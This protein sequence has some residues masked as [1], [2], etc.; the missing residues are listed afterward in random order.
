MLLLM[1]ALSCLML[2]SRD[3]SRASCHIKLY[4]MTRV[5]HSHAKHPGMLN[6]M[7]REKSILLV[8]VVGI[9]KTR[10]NIMVLV[11]LMVVE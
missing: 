9:T 8:T 2:S 6:Q 5:L 11:V 1:L 4:H 3:A 7:W 10:C